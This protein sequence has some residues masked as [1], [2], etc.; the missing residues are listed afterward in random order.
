M[1]EQAK[2]L[3]GGDFRIE[4]E[5]EDGFFEYELWGPGNKFIICGGGFD[6][7][8]QLIDELSELSAG[9]KAI[10]G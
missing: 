4:I 2:T 5:E 3:V 9:L 10:F 7:Y 6:T 1:D 8:D